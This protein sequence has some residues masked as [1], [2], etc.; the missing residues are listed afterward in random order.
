MTQYTGSK[1]IGTGQRTGT[2]SGSL[3]KNLLLVAEVA[4]ESSLLLCFGRANPM[5][6]TAEPDFIIQQKYIDSPMATMTFRLFSVNT[7]EGC[8]I[9]V[10]AAFNAMHVAHLIWRNSLA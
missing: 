6:P 7:F 4:E 1:I 2:F 8:N 3:K 5:L 9:R 10:S